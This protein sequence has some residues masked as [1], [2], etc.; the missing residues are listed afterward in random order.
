[1][2]PE[3]YFEMEET[4]ETKSEYFHGEIF[5]MTGASHRHNVISVNLISWLNAG[6]LDQDCFVYGGDMKVEVDPGRH[7]AYPDASVVCGGVEFMDDRTDV[8]KNPLVIFEILS[9]ST[10]DYDMGAKFKA[11]RAIP[12][13]QDYIVIDQYSVFATHF[14]KNKAGQWTL[15]DFESLEDIVPI[16]SLG[17][18]MEMKEI[19]RRIEFN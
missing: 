13:L 12:S 1:M 17:L 6:L 15:N 4:S 8:F 5:A 14:H 9:K 11:Y 16:R 3:A 7:Y 18:E 10:W 19:Y 2:P